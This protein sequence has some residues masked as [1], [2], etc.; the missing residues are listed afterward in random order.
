MIRHQ[1]DHLIHCQRCQDQLQYLINEVKDHHITRGSLL[2]LVEHETESSVPARAVGASILPTP[3]PKARYDEAI[4]LQQAYCELYMRVASDPDWLYKVLEPLKNHDRFFDVLWEVYEKV[5]EAGA[6][7]NVVCCV[8]RNDYMIHQPPDQSEAEL[9]QVEMNTFSCAGAAH[10]ERIANVHKHLARVR[11]CETGP[12]S[13]S[14][15]ALPSNGNVSSI[16]DMLQ[17]AHTIYTSRNPTP[18]QKCILITVQPFNF[19]V[20]DERPIE[21]ALWDANIPCYRVE[22]RTLV[23]H[24]TLTSDHTLLFKPPF[25]SA[26][27]EV[28]VLYYRGGYVIEEYKPSGRELRIRLEISRAIKCPDILTHLAGF[29]TVQAALT[30]SGALERFLPDQPENVQRIRRTFMHMQALDT[31][32][33]GRHFRATATYEPCSLNQPA[34]HMPSQPSDPGGGGW[35]LKP[36]RDGGGHNVYRAAI[37]PFLRSQPEEGWGKY[38]MMQMIEPPATEGTLM[39]SEGLYHG[40]VISELGVLG[41]CVWERKEGGGVGVVMNE[42]GGWTFKTKPVGVDEMSVVKGFGCFDCPM[43]AD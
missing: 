26:E 24:T 35:V 34:V 36:N 39:A 37:L 40:A 43:L 32:P 15:T 18:H 33:R 14:S 38:T 8:F 6:V 27:R 17:T 16:V 5:R 3:F 19:N 21:L 10:A 30:E 29:K 42:V 28:S 1:D 7:Q 12:S 13:S 25:G 22:W 20:A 31:T 9:K 4:E 11:D 41:T 2:K 23:S